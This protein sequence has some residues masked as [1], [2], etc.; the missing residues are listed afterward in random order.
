ML[1]GCSVVSRMFLRGKRN[2][3]PIVICVCH[4]WH[5]PYWC[6]PYAVHVYGKCQTL[7][8][9]YKWKRD[10]CLQ[11]AL[12]TLFM[13]KKICSRIVTAVERRRICY[14][15]VRQTLADGTLQALC[16]H[17]KRGT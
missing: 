15:L 11:H 17:A 1:A 10:A 4:A 9:S 16:S 3:I 12:L 6:L 14:H 2:K 13:F 7:A 8:D 5:M